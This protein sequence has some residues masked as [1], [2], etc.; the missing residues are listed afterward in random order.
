MVYCLMTETHAH[1]TPTAML[2]LRRTYV[3]YAHTLF[4]LMHME[5]DQ[6]QNCH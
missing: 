2:F 3:G 4:Y 1:G 5:L 6:T